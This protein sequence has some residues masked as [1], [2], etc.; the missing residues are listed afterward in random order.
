MVPTPAMAKTLPSLVRTRMGASPPTA[1]VGKLGDGRGEHGGDSRI[2]GVAAAVKHA[3]AGL[4]GVLGPAGNGATGT[5]RGEA[6][7]A[8]PSLLRKRD[9]SQRRRQNCDSEFHRLPLV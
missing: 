3:H 9:E 8:L 1:E 6:Y 4:G 2:H 7:R 5:A